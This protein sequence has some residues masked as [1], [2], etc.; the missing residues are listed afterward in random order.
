MGQVYRATNTQLH[1]DVA[2]KILPDAVAAT[3]LLLSSAVLGGKLSIG[4]RYGP[5]A[6]R[7]C[8][9][10]LGGRP[11]LEYRTQLACPAP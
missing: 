4:V 3:N 11:T 5:T 6:A 10:L 8:V 7:P 9:R 1:R 2:L